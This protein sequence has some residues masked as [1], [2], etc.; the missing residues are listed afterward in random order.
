MSD[1]VLHGSNSEDLHQ[2]RRHMYD[3][4]NTYHRSFID[5][6]TG[7]ISDHLLEGRCCPVCAFDASQKIFIK[8]GGTYVKCNKCGMIY[9]NPVFKDDELRRYY[10]NNST[11]QADSH[12][13]ESAFYYAIYSRGLINIQKY[14]L[15]GSILDIGCSSGFFLDVAIDYGWQTYGIELNRS[16]FL[17]AQ[18][19]KHKVW[20]L[21]IEEI[22]PNTKFTAIFMWDV[23][24][25]IKDGNKYLDY[26]RN[27][28]ADNGLIFLQI[29]NAA[30]IAARV[31]QDRCNMFDG[32]E[33]VNLY[34]PKT[35][36]V[37]CER[38]GYHILYMET[39]IDELHVLKKYLNYEDPY[40]GNHIECPELDF[41]TTEL[42][43]K[44][45]LGYKLQLILKNQKK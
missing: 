17:I 38:L 12:T 9:L 41:L 36:T 3:I 16:E 31:L 4:C 34:T 13:N 29:P 20:N 11:V 1:I 32:I 15:P 21:P 14:S 37:L 42:I 10:E 22:S 45:K 23:L 33:H 35:I 6:S 43:H 8:N 26:L 44:Y 28:I 40:F 2:G 5:E 18:S 19:K 7:L 39:V 30:S 24:E 27:H 25:H